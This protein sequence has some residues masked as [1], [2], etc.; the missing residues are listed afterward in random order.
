MSMH[1]SKCHI[2]GN[3]MSQ[4]ICFRYIEEYSCIIE[5]IK[6]DAEK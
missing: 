2:V 6:Q 1:L 4:L 3:Y 5:F